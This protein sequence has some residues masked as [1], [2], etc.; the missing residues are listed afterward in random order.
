MED[1][2]VHVVHD[3]ELHPRGRRLR[4]AHSVVQEPVEL[5]A[6]HYTDQYV[7]KSLT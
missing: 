2:V 5:W 6:I 7:A 3:L 4:R 1:S